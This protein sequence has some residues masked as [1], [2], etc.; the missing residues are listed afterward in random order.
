MNAMRIGRAESCC[1][2]M[3]LVNECDANWSSRKLLRGDKEEML[4]LSRSL[5]VLEERELLEREML[6]GKVS[7][8]WLTAYG[9]A[10]AELV[11]SG[12]VALVASLPAENT[13]DG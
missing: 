13:S 9:K 5:K 12:S 6:G 3:L 7:T 11:G 1:V 10:C 2:V 8:V 4:S